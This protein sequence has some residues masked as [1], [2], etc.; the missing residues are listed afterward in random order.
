MCQ[1]IQRAEN[2]RSHQ[3]EPSHNQS[4]RIA[5]IKEKRA[6]TYQETETNRPNERTNQKERDCVYTSEWNVC[7][8]CISMP[9][10]VYF[11]HAFWKFVHS[12]D[13]FVCSGL[14][15]GLGYETVNRRV[16]IFPAF[17]FTATFESSKS[18]KLLRLFRRKTRAALDIAKRI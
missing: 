16:W 2:K 10:S 4:D 17:S 15:A 1:Q 11:V 7:I 3:C 18:E 14:C 12:L 5:K 9:Y 8:Y 6:H 13:G